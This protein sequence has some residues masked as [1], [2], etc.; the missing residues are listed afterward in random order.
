M[1]FTNQAVRLQNNSE[2]ELLGLLGL[3]LLGNLVD[4]LLVFRS[5]TFGEL[6]LSV[7]GLCGTI[8]IG[9]VIDDELDYLLLS[10]L[11]LCDP[12]LTDGWLDIFYLRMEI[13][14]F[15]QPSHIPE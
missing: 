12:G 3:Q 5:T 8:S 15:F 1:G 6:E 4:E 14:S 10:G 9:K 7:G 13:V 11:L 2:C